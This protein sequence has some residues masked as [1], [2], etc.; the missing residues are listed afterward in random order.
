MLT[1]GYGEGSLNVGQNGA[2][3]AR[4]Y[5]TSQ[6]PAASHATARPAVKYSLIQAACPSQTSSPREHQPASTGSATRVRTTLRRSRTSRC[7]SLRTFNQASTS[8]RPS[9][10]PAAWSATARPCRSSRKAP[11][12]A[13]ARPIPRSHHHDARA[14]QA[15]STTTVFHRYRQR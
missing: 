8:A 2:V 10:P 14:D 11:K 3:R 12:S 13:A 5:Q 9:T 6:Q 15:P 4:P 7:R 1:G